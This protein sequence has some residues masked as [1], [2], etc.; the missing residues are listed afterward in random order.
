M[1]NVVET[2][3]AAGLTELQIAA[4]IGIA[5]PTLREYF[6]D[7]LKNG[8]ARKF[9]RMVILLDRAAE[10]GSVSAMK[11][12]SLLFSGGAYI[13]K[14]QRQEQEA[15]NPAGGIWGDDLVPMAKLQ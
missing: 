15:A 3:A 1:R 14:K 6:C 7:E 13:G 5:R 12:L 10:R 2:A 11:F 9:A 8:R 4:V